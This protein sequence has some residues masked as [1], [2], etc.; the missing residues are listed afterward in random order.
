MT[1]SVIINF[2]FAY[3]PKSYWNLHIGVVVGAYAYK[4]VFYS[5]SAE[6]A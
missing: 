4:A 1:L 3:S 6:W 2:R 5:S